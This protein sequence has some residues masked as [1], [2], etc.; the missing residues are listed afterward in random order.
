MTI[1]KIAAVPHWKVIMQSSTSDD[2]EGWAKTREEQQQKTDTYPPRTLK[3][4]HGKYIMSA[5]HLHASVN[6]P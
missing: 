5:V 6:L 2:R 1:A 4:N 3:H